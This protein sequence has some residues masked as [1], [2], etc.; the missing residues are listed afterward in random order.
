MKKET[1]LAE[2]RKRA[3][4]TTAAEATSSYYDGAA[5]LATIAEHN[6]LFYL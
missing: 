5:I 6:Y 2:Q 3:R 4:I 1:T